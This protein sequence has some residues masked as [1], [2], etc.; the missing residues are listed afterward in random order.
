MRET[1][2]YEWPNEDPPDDIKD[3]RIIFRADEP[4]YITEEMRED[5]NAM[6]RWSP[7]IHMP[8]WASRITLQITNVRIE[9]LKE[10]TDDDCRAE[11][12]TGL[13]GMVGA[14]IAM[15]VTGAKTLEEAELF[16]LAVNFIEVWDKLNAKR[17]Y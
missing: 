9:R 15:L 6:Y 1:F 7:S 12:I 13:G 17:G 5:D 16:T 14:N 11:G 4:N 3:C 10:L 8:R 2:Y